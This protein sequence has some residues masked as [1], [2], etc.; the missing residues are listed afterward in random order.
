MSGLRI[1]NKKGAKLID[2]NEFCVGLSAI[3]TASTNNERQLGDNY[4][5]SVTITNFTN[6]LIVMPLTDISNIV[7]LD[8]M[9]RTG[10]ELKLTFFSKNPSVAA[11]FYIFDIGERIARLGQSYFKVYNSNGEI[12]FDNSMQHLNILGEVVNN[13]PLD[14]NKSY[15]YLV[16][17]KPN[18]QFI[19]RVW[20][21]LGSLFMQQSFQIPYKSDN[22]LK[23]ENVVFFKDVQ[24]RGESDYHK[25]PG[26]FSGDVVV[27]RALTPL[28]V[29]LTNL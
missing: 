25:Y 12:T 4:V 20:F 22:V 13:M 8:A 1:Y 26:E 3:Y 17:S 5:G 16:R 2:S 23:Y 28:L 15:G 27:D 14:S 10:N 18:S 7:A 29:D 11:K 6:P 19:G 24:G 9:Q 21:S